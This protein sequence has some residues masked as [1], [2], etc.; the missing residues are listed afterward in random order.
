PLLSFTA[1]P[2]ILAFLSLIF[3]LHPRPHLCSRSKGEVGGG[4]L[5]GKSEKG[6]W[7]MGCAAASTITRS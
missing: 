2:S 3:L 4:F 6:A 5:H 7:H 1:H